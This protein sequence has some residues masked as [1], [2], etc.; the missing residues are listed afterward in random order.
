MRS[1]RAFAVSS[2][3]FIA[4]SFGDL[5]VHATNAPLTIYGFRTHGCISLHSDDAR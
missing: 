1:V 4:L 3:G 2:D 5:G